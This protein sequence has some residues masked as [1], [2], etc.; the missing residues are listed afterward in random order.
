MKSFKLQVVCVALLLWTCVHVSFKSMSLINKLIL[1]FL[2]FQQCFVYQ[3]LFQKLKSYKRYFCVFIYVYMYMK[4]KILTAH[5]G[6]LVSRSDVERSIVGLV[7]LEQ[8]CPL[9]ICLLGHF[10]IIMPYFWSTRT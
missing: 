4:L 3:I 9:H 8:N 7:W 2:S 1:F 5:A 10:G 6:Q